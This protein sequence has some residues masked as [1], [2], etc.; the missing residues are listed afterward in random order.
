[1]FRIHHIKTYILVNLHSSEIRKHFEGR[2]LL[3]AA[4]QLTKKHENN[5]L[6]G[7]LFRKV[8]SFDDVLSDIFS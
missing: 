1:M 8:L 3:D 7:K 2:S 5:F 4:F 6:P